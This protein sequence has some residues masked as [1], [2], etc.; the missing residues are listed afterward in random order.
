MKKRKWIVVYDANKASLPASMNT[1][2]SKPLAKKEAKELL[3]IFDDA[4][5]ML[6]IKGPFKGKIIKKVKK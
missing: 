3:E 4:I 2:Q 5:F 6:K 1:F